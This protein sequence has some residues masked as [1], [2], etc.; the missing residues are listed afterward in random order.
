VRLLD[1]FQFDKDGN[2][3]EYVEKP[4]RRGVVSVELR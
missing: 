1:H 2:L 3:I 4:F